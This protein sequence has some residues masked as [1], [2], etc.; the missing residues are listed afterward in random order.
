LLFENAAVAKHGGT[1]PFYRLKEEYASLFH[2]DHGTLASLDPEHILK[3]LSKRVD[4]AEALSVTEVSS[5]TFSELLAK[6]GIERI[7]L[8]QIDAEGRDAEIIETI[9]FNV[10]KPGIIRFEH[11]NIEG[12][13]KNECIELL[14]AHSYKLVI[15]AYDITAFQSRWMY[16]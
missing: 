9:D 6:H 8:L 15:G 11:A 3:H 10:V 1:L 5:V 2:A 13:R 7:D 14:L 16:D 12:S 4:A